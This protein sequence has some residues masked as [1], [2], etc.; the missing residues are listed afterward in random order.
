M[1]KEERKFIE[2]YRVPMILFCPICGERHIDEHEWTVKPHHTHSCQ[3]CGFTWRPAVV[4]TIGVQFLPGF[5]N[6]G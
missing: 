2:T 5:K 1:T 4:N 6:D 3:F